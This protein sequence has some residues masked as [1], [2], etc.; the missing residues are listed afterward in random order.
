[1]GETK[2]SIM[3][4]IKNIEEYFIKEKL[5]AHEIMI[6]LRDLENTALVALVLGAQEERAKRVSEQIK[7]ESNIKKK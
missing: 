4:A 2:V 6:I 1:M 3:D 5:T 7:S